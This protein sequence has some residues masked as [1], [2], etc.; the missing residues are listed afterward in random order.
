MV[1]VILIGAAAA[2]VIGVGLLLVLI[3]YCVC[4]RRAGKRALGCLCDTIKASG[5][6]TIPIDT[7]DHRIVLS[8]GEEQIITSPNYPDMYDSN[9]NTTTCVAVEGDNEGNLFYQITAFDLECCCDHLSI[10][11]NGIVCGETPDEEIEVPSNFLRVTF[12]SDGSVGYQGFNLRVWIAASRTSATCGQDY[13][14]EDGESLIIGSPNYPSDYAPNVDCITNI[15]T[16]VGTVISVQFLL[17]DLECCCDTVKINR[18]QQTCGGHYQTKTELSTGRLE[19]SFTSDSFNQHRGFLMEVWAGAA[20][21]VTFNQA[22]V[23]ILTQFGLVA[24]QDHGTIGIQCLESPNTCA[25]ADMICNGR[26]D[27]TWSRPFSFHDEDPD[28]CDEEISNTIPKRSADHGEEVLLKMLT[29][30]QNHT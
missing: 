8:P 29:F 25:T 17:F 21:E 3:T 24:C 22:F 28:F 30:L 26:H 14:L 11:G 13:Q 15:M 1:D 2:A 20:V 4:G 10:N 18:I 19:L 9:S 23:D 16:N 12:T 6:E 5:D 27:C 7:C